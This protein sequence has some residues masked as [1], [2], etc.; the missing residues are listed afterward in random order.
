MSYASYAM[1]EMPKVLY[2]ILTPCEWTDFQ[3]SGSFKGSPLDQKD[4][5]IHAALE[6][7]YSKIMEKFFKGVRPIVLI[8]I[9]A[10]RLP[11]ARIKIEA[12]KPGGDTFPHIY[13][14]IPLEAVVSSEVIE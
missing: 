11:Q 4:G 9:D 1:E 6:S 2:K 7:Q 3:K 8:K 10:T 12:N 13:G 14:T 5:F